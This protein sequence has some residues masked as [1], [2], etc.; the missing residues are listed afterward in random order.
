MTEPVHGK[1]VVLEMDIDG[2]DNFEVVLCG[3][4]CSFSRDLEFVEITGP[5]SGLFADFM[6]RKETWEMSVNGLTKVLTD[7][8]LTFFYMLQTAVRR[9]SHN[10]RMTFQKLSFQRKALYS[11]Q[12]ST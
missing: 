9:S 11:Y 10:F 3:I 4:D 8:G 7:A 1:N 6:P 2:L 5:T 12:K